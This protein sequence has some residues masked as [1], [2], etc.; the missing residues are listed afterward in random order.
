MFR[1]PTPHEEFDFAYTKLDNDILVYMKAKLF[2]IES[3]EE[4]SESNKQEITILTEKVF[5]DAA[6]MLGIDTAVNFTFY[7]FGKKNGGFTQA[8]DWIAVTLPK[9]EID[10]VDL[11]GMLYHE[12]HHIAR[13]YCGYM[14][15]KEHYLLNSLFS[16][17]LATAFEL[18]KQPNSR[19]TTHGEYDL[20]L[21]TTWLPQTKNEFYDTTN[22]DYAGWFLGKGRPKQLGYK[23]GKYL[24]DEIKRHHS[25]LTHRELARKDAK[26]LLALSEVII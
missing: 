26:E 7:R 20:D 2:F 18:E 25:E 16:E 10:Y 5:L 6:E 11:E 21:V 24:V 13:G 15:N 1:H 14:E 22:Y 19:E 3:N 12:L 23:L 8:K 4:F 17:G 9:G